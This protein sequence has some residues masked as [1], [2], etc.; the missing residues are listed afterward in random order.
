MKLFGALA[1]AM[2][3]LIGPSPAHQSWIREEGET[4]SVLFYRK[5]L[6]SACFSG[7]RRR[8]CSSAPFLAVSKNSQL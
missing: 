5:R 7:A 2:L 4:P 3:L 6:L 1:V 8:L